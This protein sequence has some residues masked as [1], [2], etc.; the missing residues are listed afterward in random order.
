MFEKGKGIDE[1]CKVSW[2]DRTPQKPTEDITGA[3]DSISPPTVV[4]P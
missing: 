3:Q 4:G 2:L 1:T